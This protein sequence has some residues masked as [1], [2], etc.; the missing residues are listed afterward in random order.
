MERMFQEIERN[1]ALKVNEFHDRIHSEY[2]II[3]NKIHHS[4]QSTLRT[5]SNL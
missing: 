2:Q 4:Y 3:E 1:L 5:F